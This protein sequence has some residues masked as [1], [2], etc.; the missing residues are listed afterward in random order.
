MYR[1]KILAKVESL[2]A[3]PIAFQALWDGDSTGW[4]IRFSAVTQDGQTHPL[5]GCS[6]G[7]DIR[8]VNGQVPPWPEAIAAHQLGHELAEQ[9]GASFYLPSP[10]HP[11]E[12][13][14]EWRERDKGYPCRRCG[15]LLLQRDDCPWHGLCYHCHLDE[16][17]EQR[18]A[19]WTPEQ[20]QG[21]RCHICGNPATNELN[22]SPACADCFDRYEVYT[23]EK[24]GCPCMISKSRSH[25]SLCHRCECQNA[26]GSLTA[27]Q[28]DTIRAAID[29]GRLEGIKTVMAVMGCSLN[30]A[31]YMVHVLGDADIT[32][33]LA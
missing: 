26:I 31:D 6:D 20:R 30:E 24:C 21:P 18:E 23:C 2:N 29:K 4:F 10:D 3:T 16:E 28:R 5:G 13:C 25:S 22:G 17:R 15:I 7:G 12:D 8:L 19:K 27:T 32:D 1:E 9:Y 11:E 14:P 33:G